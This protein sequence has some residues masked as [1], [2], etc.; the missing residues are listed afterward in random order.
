MKDAVLGVTSVRMQ[1]GERL[2]VGLLSRV[3]V[4]WVSLAVCRGAD[5]E[6][7]AEEAEAATQSPQATGGVVQ[8]PWGRTSKGAG[9]WSRVGGGRAGPAGPVGTGST[10]RLPLIL[11]WFKVVPGVA[12]WSGA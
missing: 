1:R 6:G 11:Y 7:V 12:M 2:K 9:G 3:G 10:R 4:P 8:R 5:L